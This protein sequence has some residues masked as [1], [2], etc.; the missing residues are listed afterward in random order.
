M[1]RLSPATPS[2]DASFV[3]VSAE[4]SLTSERVITAGSGI[5]LTDGGAGTTTTI[6]NK[7]AARGRMKFGA[8]TTY[9]MPPGSIAMAGSGLFNL[10]QNLDVFSPFIVEGRAIT[11][12]RLA[13][14]VATGATGNL[15]IGMTQLDTDWQPTGAPL[16]DSGD[17]S[18][19]A[20]GVKE[21]VFSAAVT[22]Q[23]G[24]YAMVIN[25]TGGATLRYYP[26]QIPGWALTTSMGGTPF[27]NY[28][29]KS[30]TYAAFPNP[31]TIDTPST[32]A[33]PPNQGTYVVMGISTPDAG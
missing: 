10:T 15:R 20:G 13:S 14:E 28:A 32:I 6:T 8:T 33:G 25:K 30:R 27:Y 23:P 7:D 9:N 4:G 18:T 17:I 24:R 2:P 26:Y 21:F 5:T 12:D 31:M 3:T 29:N 16:C 1:P 22:L 19:A 11:V